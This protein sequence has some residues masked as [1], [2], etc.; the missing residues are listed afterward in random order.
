MCVC[1]CVTWLSMWEAS[2]AWAVSKVSGSRWYRLEETPLAS[3]YCSYK[4]GHNM[5]AMD[6]R[7]QRRG[8]EGWRDGGM[9]D[10]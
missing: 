10:G 2:R 3:R 4:G 8:V 7:T 5:D 6:T 1:V 9:D